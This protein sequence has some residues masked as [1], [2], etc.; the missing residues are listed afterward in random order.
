M[1]GWIQWKEPSEGVREGGSAGK[2]FVEQDR[3]MLKEKWVA[4]VERGSTGLRK[5]PPAKGS[6]RGDKCFSVPRGTLRTLTLTSDQNL[7]KAQPSSFQKPCRAPKTHRK[8]WETSVHQRLEADQGVLLFLGGLC[9]PHGIKGAIKYNYV[10]VGTHPC[11]IASP[12][13]A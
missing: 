7:T 11:T 1:I 12:R 13:P 5:T 9:V 4:N 10:P 2:E 8:C 6:R 3:G